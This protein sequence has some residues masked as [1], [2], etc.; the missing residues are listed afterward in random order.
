MLKMNLEEKD[1]QMTIKDVAV[2]SG[3][4]EEFSKEGAREETLA[5]LQFIRDS[6]IFS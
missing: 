3:Y 1:L 2:L 5:F 6:R 4:W